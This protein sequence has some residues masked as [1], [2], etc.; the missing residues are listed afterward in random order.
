GG[1]LITKSWILTAAE[2]HCFFS[3][4]CR[5]AFASIS[6]HP[7][8]EVEIKAKPLIYTDTVRIHDIMLLQL[9][10]TFDIQP[11]QL[12]DCDTRPKINFQDSF[13]KHFMLSSLEPSKSPTLH[14]ANVNVVDCENLRNTLREKYL[15]FYQ[16]KK[17]HHWFCGQTPGVD[18]CYR[19]SGGGVVSKDKIYGVISFLGDPDFVCKQS[20]AIMDL[21]NPEYKAWIQKHIS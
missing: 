4:T 11:I 2:V 17:D 6:L 13:S 19:D 15:A 21:C 18:I 16:L 10:H 7:A 5:T 1:S 14:C 8:E 3:F 9:P 12:S 20:V